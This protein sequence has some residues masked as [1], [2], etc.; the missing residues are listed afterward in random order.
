VKPIW[1]HNRSRMK[2]IP[3]SCK[4]PLIN[5]RAAHINVKPQ[6]SGNG[7]MWGESPRK[8]LNKSWTQ[9]GGYLE[10]KQGMYM[11]WV[12]SPNGGVFICLNFLLSLVPNPSSSRS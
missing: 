11:Y 2:L 1:I 6:R 10:F 3:E 12:L 9:G 5:A 7:H 8:Y 4:H